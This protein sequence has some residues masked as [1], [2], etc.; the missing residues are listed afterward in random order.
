MG[1]W[2]QLSKHHPDITDGNE[3]VNV[4]E[5]GAK[6]GDQIVQGQHFY[7]KEESKEAQNLAIF[8][9]TESAVRLNDAETM[10]LENIRTRLND[11]YLHVRYFDFRVQ[12]FVYVGKWD[13]KS[14]TF[15]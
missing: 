14:Q 2:V 6:E 13:A 4:H 11:G 12:G 7:T 15:K 1:R 5:L 10:F 8:L 3:V 9:R